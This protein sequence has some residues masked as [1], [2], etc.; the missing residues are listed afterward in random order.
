[1]ERAG[2]KVDADDLRRMSVDFEQRMAVM[3]QDI[4]RLAGRAFNLG[5]AKQL[6][7]VL[8]D[9]M[10]LPG[11][12]RMKTGAWGTDASVLQS[13][14]D[15]GHELPAR[16]LEWRQ[17]AKLKSTYADAL[18]DQINPDTGRVHTSFAMAIAS[19][20]RLSSTDPNLQNIPIRT[21]EGSRIRRAFI[22]EPGHVLVS[23][24]YSQIE[25]R[26]LAHVADIPALRDSFA[27]GE[28]IHARTASE[29]FGIPMAGHGPDDAPPRQ[30]DQF[31]HHL[32]HQRLRPRPPARHPAG[33][34]AQLHRR[35]FR[36]LSRHPRL[37]GAR[38]G[39]SAHRTATSPSPFGRRCWIPGIADKNPA[40]RG[41]AERQAINAPLQGGAAD[42]IKRAMV[43]LP[44]ALR[45]AGLQARMLLQVHDELLFEAPEAEAGAL[46]GV[47]R[48]VMERAAV[49]SVPLVVET[50]V[51]KELG[52]CSLSRQSS[53]VEPGSVRAAA[54]PPAVESR[55]V[56]NC[57]KLKVRRVWWRC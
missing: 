52:G 42:I 49:L 1:M 7:E 26:L 11:G 48:Q 19:T 57:A 36:A 35:L 43:Q 25:L 16:I 55:G 20:G 41:Y 44:A 50:G 21:E 12:K 3:E 33:R 45:E 27:N 34:G 14:A 29:V 28:D 37:H 40:R 17:L 5:S 18:V 10:G 54:F 9:E 2:I 4:H 6:G 30:G 23:A 47:A 15:Q 46:A 53:R 8:F 22:A 13:L 31:R 51:G 56:P 24:D 38:A 32:R 39:G